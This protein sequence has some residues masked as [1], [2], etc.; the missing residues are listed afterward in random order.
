MYFISNQRN[1]IKMEAMGI[2]E[3]HFRV[4]VQIINLSKFKLSVQSHQEPEGKK[5]F[6]SLDFDR[7]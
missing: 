6:Q 2:D 3:A 1:S 4:A 5:T 7:L